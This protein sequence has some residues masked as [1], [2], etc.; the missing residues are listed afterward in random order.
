[1]LIHSIYLATEGEGIFIGRPQI[2]IRFQGCNV[3]CRNCD[4]KETWAFKG[5]QSTLGDVLGTIS[6]ISTSVK[7]ISITGGDPLDP[8]HQEDVL[9]LCKALKSKG[10]Y[11]NLEA[12]GNIIA[13][14]IFQIIDFISFDFKTPST[15]VATPVEFIKQMKKEFPGKFQ[16]KAVIQ[17]EEDFDATYEAY[18]SISEIGFP[19]CLT[20]AYNPMEQ[21][22][23]ARFKMVIEKNE[24]LGGPFR[25]IGQ[26]HKWVFG[27]NKRNK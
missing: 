25:V 27:P 22:P 26:Q 2:F 11:I 4:S 21:F 8:I 23:M 5:P 18:K 1:M 7:N 17:T 13:P 14:Q 16:V 12:A 10:Y 3:G 9:N 15:G 24:S 20:P 6:S 19:W